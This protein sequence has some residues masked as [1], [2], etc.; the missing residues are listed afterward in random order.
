MN[1]VLISFTFWFFVLKDLPEEI[2]Q[3]SLEKC[4]LKL[5][6]HQNNL[7]KLWEAIGSNGLMFISNNKILEE[8]KPGSLCLS[9]GQGKAAHN[10]MKAG[11]IDPL[12]ILHHAS[13][14][15]VNT[16]LYRK[17]NNQICYVHLADLLISF[18]TSRLI[19]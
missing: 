2:Y 12:S 11:G 16:W 3:R 10:L 8:N 4:F 6:N 17:K 7:N 1:L 18:S 14:S 5:K 19:C 13:I 15:H 9:F